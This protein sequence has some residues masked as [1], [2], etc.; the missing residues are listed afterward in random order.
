M[1]GGCSL[2]KSGEFFFGFWFSGGRAK[3]RKQRRVPPRPSSQTG[4]QPSFYTAP[5]S[6][7]SFF[8]SLT[9]FR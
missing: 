6:C 4:I 8:S 5:V 7:A 3:E 9:I 2:I 1:R